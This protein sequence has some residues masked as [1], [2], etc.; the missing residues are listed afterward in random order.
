MLE[1]GV[2]RLSPDFIVAVLVFPDLLLEP[3]YRPSLSSD[4]E[5]AIVLALSFPLLG[6]S[7]RPS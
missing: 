1:N 5:S 3:S 6:F 4:M 2:P 7:R